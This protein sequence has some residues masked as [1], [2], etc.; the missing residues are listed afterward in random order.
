MMRRWQQVWRLLPLFVVMALALVLTGCEQNEYLSTLTP[1]GPVAE[2]QL[3]MMKLS[4]GIMLGVFAVV[5]LIFTYVLIRYR[6]RKGDNR[7]PEQVEGNHKLEIIWTVIPFILLIIMAVPMVSMTFDFAKDYSNDKN[8]VQVKVIGHQFWWEFEYPELGIKTSQDLMIPVGKKINFEITSTDVMHSFWVPSLGGKIDNN[9]GLT[10]H[11]W[12]QADKEGIYEG[13]CAELCGASHALMDFKVIAVKQEEFDSW[14]AKM[15]DRVK[16][17]PVASADQGAEIFQK[18]CIG[19]H[20][21]NGQGGKL[22]P[23]LTNFGDRTK[24]GGILDNNAENIK[25]WLKETNTIK[26]GNKMGELG[27][28]DEQVDALTNYLQSL[29]VNQ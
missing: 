9:P 16:N 22:A 11:L 21:V 23:D 18:S 17:P 2:T 24:V 1:K 19:C 28:T 25:K 3:F 7:I 29:K 13:K 27:L 14:A 20:A 8:A 5:I 10:N 12:L 15:A 26:P 6:K 4:L